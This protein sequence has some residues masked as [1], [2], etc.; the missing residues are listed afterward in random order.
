[1][2]TWSGT[3]AVKMTPAHDP[4]DYEVAQRHNLKI[5]RVTNDDGTMNA[6]AG[7]RYQGLSGL[8]CR[9]LVVRDLEALGLLVKVEEYDHNVG[10]CYRCDTTVEPLISKQWFVKCSRWLNLPFR[11]CAA[12][13]VAIR[14]RF[15]KIYYTGW[16]TS[17]TVCISRQ[18]WWEPS[19]PGVAVTIAMRS[20]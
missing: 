2:W 17:A 4:N 6:N 18:L 3:G 1:M 5:L 10:A 9:E 15:D 14:A 7:E 19:H 16:K 12:D 11:P 13:A 20:S 8:A